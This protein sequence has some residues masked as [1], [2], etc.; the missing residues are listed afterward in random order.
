MHAHES[1]LIVTGREDSVQTEVC[2]KH[3][4][5]VT[6]WSHGFDF[7]DGSC[8]I[9]RKAHSSYC[10]CPPPH[11]SS[12]LQFSHAPPQSC[13]LQIDALIDQ[14]GEWPFYYPLKI[15]IDF[16]FLLKYFWAF[17]LLSSED[18]SGFGVLF[19]WVPSGGDVP[20]EAIMV[21]DYCN[22]R[23]RMAQLW[24]QLWLINQSFWSGT[25]GGHTINRDSLHQKEPCF[26]WNKIF[27]V[28]NL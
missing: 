23:C 16:F 18:F 28:V 13:L 1:E 24:E 19:F 11:L 7:I 22:H 20:Q 25:G 17:P 12:L 10:R 27:K 3:V 15:R 9:E 4:R 21:H 5:C 14:L 6:L 2:L 8:D 26:I